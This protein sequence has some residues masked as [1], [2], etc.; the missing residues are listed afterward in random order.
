M[1][2]H[3]VQVQHDLIN[4]LGNAITPLGIDEVVH[5]VTNR[6]FKKQRIYT[7]DEI[8]DVLDYLVRLGFVKQS[9]NKYEWI[10]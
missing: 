6:G 8:I 2:V 9:N 3:N 7:D 5:E 4:T 10:K 1:T